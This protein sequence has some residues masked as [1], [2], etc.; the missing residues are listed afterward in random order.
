MTWTYREL[1]AVVAA[2]RIRNGDRILV[3][4]GM[5]NLAANLA[6]RLCAPDAVLLFEAGIIGAEPTRLA[7]S[8]GDPCL[9]TGAQAIYSMFELMSFFVQGGHIDVGFLSCAQVDR[10]GN[11]NTTVIGDY[12][13]PTTRLP[14][15]GGACE[16]ASLAQR[17]LLL[18]PH[19]PRRFVERVDFVTSPGY[20][21]GRTQ[22]EALRLA[23]GPEAVI[24]D[25][26]V[27]E[28]DAA[29]EMVLVSV[30]P[31]VAVEKV[32]QNTGWDL[33]CSPHLSVTEP[34]TDHELATLRQLD[35][36]G[37]YL[38]GRE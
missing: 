17:V 18:M 28:F 9:V 6:K 32:V 33:R 15:S 24:T 11:M 20:L 38:R 12:A 19:S 30:H 36:A 13:A 10:F 26:G 1:M 4:I 8:I 21:Q 5:P 37:I 3:G 27:L 14:G 31:D 25:L 22:R 29:G 23:G 35:P 16:I 2:R 34:P 7:L